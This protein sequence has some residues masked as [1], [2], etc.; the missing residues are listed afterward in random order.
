MRP[1]LARELE[2]T[3][4]QRTTVEAA[5]RRRDLVPRL[6]E[7]L[8]MVK[9]QRWARNRR[10]S[11]AGAGELRRRCATGWPLTRRGGSRH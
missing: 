3:A 5:L 6:R 9:A 11:R 1:V 7:R 2:V 4:A 8:E 10:P